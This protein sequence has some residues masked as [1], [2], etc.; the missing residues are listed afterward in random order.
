MDRGGGLEHLSGTRTMVQSTI[1]TVRLRPVLPEKSQRSA[2]IRLHDQEL[3]EALPAARQCSACACLASQCWQH[4][5]PKPLETLSESSEALAKFS[6]GGSRRYQRLRQE[7]SAEQL[8]QTLRSQQPIP[9]RPRVPVALEHDTMQLTLRKL[10]HSASARQRVI[11]ARWRLV[12]CSGVANQD[13]GGLNGSPCVSSQLS[14]YA[15]SSISRATLATRN[16]LKLSIMT[17]S[18][19]VCFAPML[20]SIRPGCGP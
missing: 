4:S 9:G 2:S 11:A 5:L 12:L 10:H 7:G 13:V 6:P 16:G 20:A 8:A 19:L 17:A 1:R 14:R 3:R 15:S 18:S